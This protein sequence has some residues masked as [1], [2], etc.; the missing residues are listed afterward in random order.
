MM[1]G[2]EG[3]R[4]CLRSDCEAGQIHA[5]SDAQPIVTCHECGNKTC[6]THHTPWH[7]GETCAQVDARR[8]LKAERLRQRGRTTDQDWIIRNTRPCPNRLC[9][10]PIQKAGGC[11][12]M[13][14]KR[15]GIDSSQLFP[16]AD[17]CGQAPTAGI[18][19]AGSV[20]LPGRPSYSMGM[21][22]TQRH[23]NFTVTTYL[24][25]ICYSSHSALAPRTQQAPYAGLAIDSALAYGRVRAVS[26]KPGPLR[27]LRDTK[28][29]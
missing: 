22:C 23:V 27:D 8:E 25:W 18:N 6:Y 15:G 20:P 17:P 3:F 19:S 16:I 7:E 11:E 1:Q 12:H 13:T 14:C 4:R 5:G 9:G 10:R 24:D 2:V 21:Q 29:Q 28:P 26:T